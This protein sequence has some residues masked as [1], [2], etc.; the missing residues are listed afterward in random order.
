MI[1]ITDEVI[2][3]MKNVYGEEDMFACFADAQGISA[4]SAQAIL[5]INKEKLIILFINK[6]TNNLVQK[7]EFQIE[8]ISESNIKKG[9][10]YTNI[11]NFKGR[12]QKWK[13]RIQKI[14]TLGNRQKEFLDFIQTI[15]L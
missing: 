3:E 13:F 14:L 12:G 9:M 5:L 11:W 1:L 15:N 4:I 8:E 7:I 10:F 2:I 6:I